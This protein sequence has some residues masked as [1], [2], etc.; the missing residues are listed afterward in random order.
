[1]KP[2]EVEQDLPIVKELTLWGGKTQRTSLDP[3]PALQTLVRGW[4]EFILQGL[5]SSEKT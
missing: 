2:R 5:L 1:M 3:S 4:Q